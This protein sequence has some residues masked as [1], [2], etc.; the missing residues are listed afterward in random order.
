VSALRSVDEVEGVSEVKAECIGLAS[1]MEANFIGPEF[2]ITLLTGESKRDILGDTSTEWIWE[3][4]AK[5][6]GS[7]ILHLN[8]KAYLSSAEGGEQQNLGASLLTKRD[9]RA[10][11]CLE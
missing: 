9:E 7:N 10:V 4:A 3:I 8:V 11:R 1:L 6:P 5:E 2:S